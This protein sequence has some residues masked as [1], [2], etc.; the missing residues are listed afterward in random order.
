[1]KE[2]FESNLANSQKE[3]AENQKSYEDLK[4]AKQEEIKSGQEQIDKKT[5]ELGA[6]DEKLANDKVDLE[7]TTETKEADEK[8]LADLKE[9]CKQTDQEFEQR[10][11]T[12]T[13]EIGA[14]S[15]ALNFLNSDEAHDLF[16]TGKFSASGDI[17]CDDDP[18]PR[19]PH[20]T[21]DHKISF[22]PPTAH[23]RY[24]ST[25]RH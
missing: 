24:K 6:T 1:M 13:E 7:D 22:R 8:F 16:V 18:H 23:S 5:T 12:R 21:Q 25:S 9:K 2:T 4:A 10:Q 3:E 15:Q 20:R 17:R 14:V 11:K 19:T